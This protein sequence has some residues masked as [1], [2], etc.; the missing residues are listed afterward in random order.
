MPAAAFISMAA[1]LLMI[2]FRYEYEGVPH[3]IASPRKEEYA[4]DAIFGQVGAA[5]KS[6]YAGLTKKIERSY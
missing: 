1:D 6:D 4:L 5:V 2:C 3:S